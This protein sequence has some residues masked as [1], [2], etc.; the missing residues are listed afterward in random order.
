MLEKNE[1]IHILSINSFYW[2]LILGLKKKIQFH[3][4]L[5]KMQFKKKTNK[6]I[7]KKNSLSMDTLKSGNIFL[8]LKS[9]T[10]I[11]NIATK[12]CLKLRID[13]EF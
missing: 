3:N 13:S 6:Q 2:N 5:K 4:T 7:N 9:D 1:S 8:H 12:F 11:Q 10:H